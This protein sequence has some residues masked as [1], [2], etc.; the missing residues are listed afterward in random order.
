MLARRSG[1]SWTSKDITAPHAE[2]TL[3]RFSGE[4]KLFSPDLSQA[5]MEPRDET[6]LSVEASEMTP[7]LRTNSEPH[8]FRP[9][10]TSKAPY[11][12]VP[13]EVHF[14]GTEKARDEHFVALSGASEDL[15]HVVLDSEVPLVAGADARSLYEWSGGALEVVSELPEDEGGEVVRAN[16]GSGLGSVRGA[17]SDDGSRVFWSTG[18]L[19]TGNIGITGLYLRDTDLDESVRLDVPAGGSG[20]GEPR[21][22]FQGANS[23]GSVVFFTDSRKLT[24]DAGPEGRDLY[25]CEVSTLG[26]APGCADLTNVSAPGGGGSA[27][28]KETVPALSKDGARLFFVAE[29]VL[30]SA[31]NQL[32]EIAE[33]G[34]P[35]LYFL[36][37][38]QEPR[39][40]A[41]LSTADAPNWGQT[42][43]ADFGVG[44]LVTAASSPSGRYFAF[45]SERSLTG[46]DNRNP[47][48]GELN[49]EVFLYDAVDDQL[50]CVS[51]NPFNAAAIGEQQ[52]AGT[53][54]KPRPVD[55]AG[56]WDGRAVAATL[57]E[58]SQIGEIAPSVYR[59]RAVLDN[60]RVFF[61][62]I[63]PLVP[64]DSNGDWDVYQHQ[65][66][67]TADC[68]PSS[69]NGAV[70][71]T[72][73]GCLSL[74]SSGT[75]PEGAA[76]LDASADGNDVF[77]LTRGR[78][79]VLDKDDA[80]DV[81]DARVN[82]TPAV[83]QTRSECAGEAC[84]SLGA[85]PN[86]STPASA[87]FSGKGNVKGREG[88]PKGKRK[89][90]RHGK[91]RCIRRK[92]RTHN[93]RQNQAGS[94][95]RA[96]R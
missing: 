17:V 31:P 51:C 59:P 15:A 36:Q 67:G 69:A 29:G 95:R 49:E 8:S 14:A 11:A 63:D 21:P 48:S 33:T 32:G 38:G 83:L 57:P 7:Y 20:A 39:F 43:T 12:N 4:Y 56:A 84:L 44:Y 72:G 94:T 91:T 22:V 76:F 42:K 10:V 66:I 16:L 24:A 9:L 62:A 50:T 30:D 52:P 40:I 18:S 54:E 65:P 80:V 26:G 86:D 89:V 25:R 23:D 41:S 1:G 55:I 92:Q 79:S 5:L 35:N 78:L 77:F 53:E 37:G 13:A 2:A 74:L 3:L 75:A 82:G 68:T 19:S 47:I 27:M 58:A 81:Y 71:L 93:R 90:R 64:G 6:P 88:C 61:N 46:Y 45:M 34:Q 87:T 73:D 60:G 85:P 70:S 96:H 28:V